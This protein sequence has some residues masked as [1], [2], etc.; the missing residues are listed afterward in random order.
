MPIEPFALE[1]YF[2]RYEFKV[3]YL[4]SASDCEGLSLDELLQMAAPE[5]RRLWEELR[6]GYTESAGHP[7]LRAEVA[8]LYWKMPAE[9]VIIAAPEE[10][11]F[12]LMQTL[13][14]PG[15]HVVAIAPAYQSLHEIARSMGCEV[16][17]WRLRVGEQGWELDLK[18]LEQSL[19][20]RTRLVVVNFPHNPTGYLPT[21]AEFGAL[22]E[23][24]AEHEL[25]LFCDEMYRLLEYDAADRLPSICEVYERG[26]ALSG[27]SKSFALPGLRIGWLA[28]QEAAW[29]ERW[30]TYKDY[31]T[32]CSSAPSEILAI[33]A[34]QNATAIVQR[35]QQIIRSNLALADA[36]FNAYG[37]Y[38][39]WLKPRAGSVAFPRWLGERPVEQVC[40]ELVEQRGVMLVPGSLFGFAGSHFRLGL[41]RKNFWAALEQ[42][43]QHLEKGL[44]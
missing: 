29:V 34:L 37:G 19:T 24:A 8:N 30:L 17:P 10:A 35:N 11:I 42:W 2:A 4:L 25:Y 6:L 14:N 3:Q 7:Q 28:T 9:N 21:P 41:G 1:R 33:I 32:I 43:S 13:L 39:D 22:V 15:D 23:L 20:E 5:S 31:T 18:Q 27:L 16:T 38:F 12:I 40:Q 44:L 36:F 26:I